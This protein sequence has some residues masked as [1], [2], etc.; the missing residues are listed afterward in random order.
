MARPG[1]SMVTRPMP[2][3]PM[4][5][6]EGVLA[7]LR[8]HGV[9]SDQTRSMMV[10]MPMPAPTH[11]VASAVD[12]PRALQLVQGGAQDHGAGGA[13]RVAHGDGA[14]VDVDAVERDAQVARRLHA[15]RWRRPR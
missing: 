5:E 6:G 15:A 1:M 11:R 4:L 3:A 9:A 10:A 8:R 2:S 14:A 7:C 12:L 13:Q